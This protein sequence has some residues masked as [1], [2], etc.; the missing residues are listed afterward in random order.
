MQVFILSCSL[1]RV[2]AWQKPR[3]LFFSLIFWDFQLMLSKAWLQQMFDCVL[4]TTVAFLSVIQDLKFRYWKSNRCFGIV[5]ASGR[6]D[7]QNISKLNFRFEFSLAFS[8][9]FPWLPNHFDLITLHSVCTVFVMC[10]HLFPLIPKSQ[11]VG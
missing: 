11:L 9:W 4:L 5:K 2:L 3:G 6:I 1:L 8:V 10:M 7:R